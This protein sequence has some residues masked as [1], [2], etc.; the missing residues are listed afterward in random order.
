[1]PSPPVPPSPLINENNTFQINVTN[2]GEHDIP[3]GSQFIVDLP[4]QFTITSVG[5]GSQSG[6]KIT[7]TLSS[8]L[9]SGS[10]ITAHNFSANISQGGGY[11]I[12]IDGTTM[13]HTLVEETDSFSQSITGGNTN[14]LSGGGLTEVIN[15]DSNWAGIGHSSGSGLTYMSQLFSLDLSHLGIT[16]SQIQNLTFRFNSCW[17]NPAG[18]QPACSGARPQST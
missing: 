18:G 13:S 8:A 7:Y 3:S 12:T 17:H 14:T 5:D 9:T 6:Q 15:D 10:S 16:G 11:Y 2:I 1:L 4:D